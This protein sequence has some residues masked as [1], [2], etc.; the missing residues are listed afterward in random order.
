MQRVDV[1]MK[2][3]FVGY[4]SS[5]F[6][7]DHK[8]LLEENHEVIVFDLD[9]NASSFRRIPQYLVSSTL[10]FINILNSDA[11]W[12]WF[13]DYPALPFIV[14]AKLFRKPI[15]M[16][17]AGWEVY[18]GPEINYGNQLN[19]IRGAATRWILRNSNVCVVPSN[20][21]QKITKKCEPASNV[22]VIPNSINTGLCE[23]PLPK[24][25]GVVTALISMKFTRVLKGIPTFEKATHD[26][27][28]KIIENVPHEEL[29]EI[30][31]ASK[32]YCQLS[33][34]ESFGVTVLEA[35]AC[36]CI[37]VV[38]DRDALPEVVGDCGYIV[39]YRDYKETRRCV[40]HA[41]NSNSRVESIRNRAKSF[42]REQEK[43]LTEKLLEK[44]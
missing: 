24:K 4:L 1:R 38:T 6:I 36:G 35:M 15:I 12:I 14:L 21:Y 8:E 25:N 41:L 34:T 22:I 13:A 30:L 2:I 19:P 26:M 44:L 3:F 40:E 5:H 31:K 29:I 16:R 27:N 32:V 20:A 37:P 7:Q 39:P 23:S 42:S 10:Q 33:Y 11:V 43:A 17:V 18:S 28:S 9:K